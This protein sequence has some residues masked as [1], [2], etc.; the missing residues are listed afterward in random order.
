MI[1]S[2]RQARM[3]PP[4]FRDRIGTFAVTFP[5]HTL[6]GDEVVAWINSLGEVGLNDNQCFALAMLRDGGTMDNES[7]RRV[8]G[9]DSQVARS[10][11]RDLVGRGIVTQVGSNRWTRY[12]LSSV[13]ARGRASP[14]RHA[15][16]RADRRE[17]L[18]AELASGPMSRVDLQRRT[19]LSASAV[20]RWLGI[21]RGEGLVEPTEEAVRSPNVLYRRIGGPEPSGRRPE[22]TL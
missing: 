10:E 21:M 1:S 19:G 6:L 7:Y 2:L 5:N 8:T 15:P 3:S 11:L 13:P 14:V 18:L 20:R 17:Q 9:V 12:Q 22:V 16:Q 4:E